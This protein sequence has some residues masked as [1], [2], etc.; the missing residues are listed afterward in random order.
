M[1]RFNVSG[2][3]VSYGLNAPSGV[4]PRSPRLCCVNFAAQASHEPAVMKNSA[5]Y[6]LFGK[7][8]VKRDF[9]ALDIPEYRFAA[10]GSLAP[11]GDG[12]K[13]PDAGTGLGGETI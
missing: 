8:P 4:N 10:V 9:V 5:S 7:L 1:V 3:D 12:G 2:N 11:A 6:G 13:P